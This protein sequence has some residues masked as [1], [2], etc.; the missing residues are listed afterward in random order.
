MLKL[1]VFLLVTIFSMTASVSM[2]GSSYDQDYEYAGLE[3]FGSSQLTEPEINKMLR[4]SNGAGIKSIKKNVA[5]L[6]EKIHK[7]KLFANVQIITADGGRAFV[8]V[9]IIEQA[10]DLIPTRKLT[11]PHHVITR[12]QKPN[13]LLSKLNA[14]LD[15]LSMEGRSW[16]EEYKDGIK[17]YSDEPAN[18]IVTD[19]RRFAP[20]MRT[21][22]LEV[23]ACDPD[24]LVRVEAIE[25][26]NWSQ[27]YADTCYRLLGAIDDSNYRV[28]AQAVRFIYNR[29]ETLPD[30]FPFEDLMHAL[31][32]QVRRP[33]HDDRVKSLYMMNKVLNRKPL[34]TAMAK[35]CCEKEV[36]IYC[37]K[38][39]IPSLR[40]IAERLKIRFTQPLPKKVI[41]R[42][43]PDSPGF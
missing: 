12:S 9:D 32:R 18:Q 6:E 35:E 38:S 19:I 34:L 33:S 11:N 17:Y 27:N 31:C 20:T 4:L 26:L 40:K 1:K 21:D 36:N 8:A 5:R 29:F 3:F 42:A 30:N 14:R 10:D 41:R 28:R 2:A 37:E 23:V 24:P 39:V 13:M 43:K 22:W 15:R 25:L 7:L 16:K